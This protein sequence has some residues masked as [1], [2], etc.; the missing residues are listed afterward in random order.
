MGSVLPPIISHT[1]VI[2]SGSSRRSLSRRSAGLMADR[3]AS[4]ATSFMF[5]GGVICWLTNRPHF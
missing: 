4:F 1:E 5:I 2:D 3:H